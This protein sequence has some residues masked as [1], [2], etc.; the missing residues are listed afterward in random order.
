[1]NSKR[2][3]KANLVR[4]GIRQKDIAEKAGVSPS[5]VCRILS[6]KS[7]SKNIEATINAAL[8]AKSVA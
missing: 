6:G 5:A 3:L 7:K 1:M 8:S 2:K 4:A